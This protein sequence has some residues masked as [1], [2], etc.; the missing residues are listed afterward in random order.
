MLLTFCRNPT[1]NLNVIKAELKKNCIS[2]LTA[3]HYE[4][5]GA[6]SPNP[7]WNFPQINLFEAEAE[8][9]YVRFFEQAFEWD[10]ISMTSPLCHRA[11]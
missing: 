4:L 1:A 11:V 3:Q 2:V 6:I 9:N 10:Q 5:F 7:T 8:G